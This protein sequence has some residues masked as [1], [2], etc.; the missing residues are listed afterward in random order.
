[1]KQLKD[2]YDE[3]IRVFAD[4]VDNIAEDFMLGIKE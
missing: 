1:M 4:D 2:Y 3:P